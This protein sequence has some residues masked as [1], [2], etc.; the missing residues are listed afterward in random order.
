MKKW[1]DRTPTEKGMIIVIILL[2]IGILVRW[3]SVSTGVK[4]GFERMFNDNETVA[5]TE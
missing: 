4:G 2:V 1:N 5:N 3:N